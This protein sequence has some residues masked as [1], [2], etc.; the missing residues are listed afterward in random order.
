M[1]RVIT[2]AVVFVVVGAILFYFG[3]ALTP[4][5]CW[6]HLGCDYYE[7]TLSLSGWAGLLV[8]AAG[9]ITFFE[10]LLYTKA[11]IVSKV[12]LAVGVFLLA[13]IFIQSFAN[14]VV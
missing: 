1:K 3:S 12:V 10:A 14:I 7:Q 11:A 2:G 4:S 8:G 5:S 9:A 6:G 13:I